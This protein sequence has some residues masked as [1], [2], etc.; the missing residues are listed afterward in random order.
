MSDAG[1]YLNE[2]EQEVV[3]WVYQNNKHA[4][5]TT[6]TLPDAKCLYLAVRSEE[7]SSGSGRYCYGG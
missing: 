3:S 7:G 1:Q 5:A 2:K 4:G 6:D